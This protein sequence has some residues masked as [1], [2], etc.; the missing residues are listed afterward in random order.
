MGTRLDIQGF[1]KDYCRGLKDRDLLV[2]YGLHPKE[3]IG[4]VRRLIN[5]GHLSKEQYFDRNRVI[6]EIEARQEKD[7]LKSLYHCP[8]CSHIH[9]TAFT[10]CPACG[11]DVTKESIAEPRIQ[12]V[13][14]ESPD[15]G[16]LVIIPEKTK[17]LADTVPSA[18]EPVV[19]SPQ[20]VPAQTISEP[21]PDESF[22]E[23]V[24]DMIGVSL[25]QVVFSDETPEEISQGSY[26]LVEILEH[27]AGSTLFTALDSYDEERPLLNVRVFHLEQSEDEII[28]EF[29]ERAF[30]YQF[31]MRDANILKVYGKTLLEGKPTLVCEHMPSSLESLLKSA[32]EG[33]SLDL[34]MDLLPQVL[35]AVGYSHMHRGADGIARRLPHGAL[36][37]KKFLFDPGTNTVKLDECGIWKALVEV[38][39]FKRRMFDE[40]EV[41][42]AM[43]APECFVLDSKFVNHFFADIYALGT[44]LYRLVTGKWAFKAAG[45]EEYRFAHLKT[46]PVP[47]RVHRWQIPG[48]L[49]AMILKCL[50]KELSQRW[51]SATQMEVTIGKSY[52]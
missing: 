52:T 50:E 4:V 34:F 45:I 21:A 41:D 43:L 1:V 13:E 17:A 10:I 46:Y 3:L 7:F 51:R 25:D 37:L 33:I 32:H 49:D 40:P 24:Q 18:P 29:M 16:D 39:G 31:A 28:S 20:P 27:T 15:D 8:V 36:S 23:E 44:T 48:W 22:P 26:N 2:K 35:N 42:P 12:A 5:D 11:M 38:R 30:A 9:P 19:T 6:Q 14:S 47:P